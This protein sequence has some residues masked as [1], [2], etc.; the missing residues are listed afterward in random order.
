MPSALFE[1]DQQFRNDKYRL[2][3][4][5]DE[6]GRGPLAGPVMIA[7]VIL[8]VDFY[9]DSIHDSKQLKEKERERLDSLIRRVALDYA[10]VSVS[11]EEIDRWNIRQATLHGM[12][13]AISSLRPQPDLVLIDGEEVTGLGVPARKIIHG[14]TLSLSI[15]AASI[16]AKVL[17]DGMMNYYHHIYPEY[18]FAEHKGYGTKEHRELIRRWGPSPIHRKSFLK[19]SYL[20]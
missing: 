9:H 7:A 15:A 1:F 13:R 8:P 12:K 4:G 17:R 16:L 2:I 10:L 20:W 3:A 14:D 6:A 5:V 18:K 11:H 19:K